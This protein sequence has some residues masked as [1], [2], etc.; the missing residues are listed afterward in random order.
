MDFDHNEH[1]IL[2]N[3]MQ[4]HNLARLFQWDQEIENTLVSTPI[5]CS[6]EM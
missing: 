2:V 6:R 5:I 4:R 3:L 1:R